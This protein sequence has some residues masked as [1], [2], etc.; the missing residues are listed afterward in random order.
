LASSSE[1]RAEFLTADAAHQRVLLSVLLQPGAKSNALA[2]LHG[3]ALKIRITAPAVDNKANAALVAYLSKLLDVAPGS[4]RIRS[5]RHSRRKR[6]EI[7]GSADV[8][9]AQLRAAIAD[10]PG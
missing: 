3:D 5:G 7:T 4:I 6:L 10:L 2:G 1:R 9:A 8:I